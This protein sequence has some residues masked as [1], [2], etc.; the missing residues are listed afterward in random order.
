MY[1]IKHDG[2]LTAVHKDSAE[3]PLA[4]FVDEADAR[5]YIRKR[6]EDNALEGLLDHIHAAEPE[7]YEIRLL[8]GTRTKRGPRN[9]N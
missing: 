8:G 9:F 3:V 2:P 4:Y 5:Y 1:T 7:R 6:E